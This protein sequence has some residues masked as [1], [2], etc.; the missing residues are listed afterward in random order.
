MLYNLHWT[1]STETPVFCHILLQILKGTFAHIKGKQ[2]FRA[3]RFSTLLVHWDDRKRS[4]RLHQEDRTDEKPSALC[5]GWNVLQICE[6]ATIEAQSIVTK[7][8]F[9][10]VKN[11]YGRNDDTNLNCDLIFVTWYAW[12]AFFLARS[13][14]FFIISQWWFLM[15][16]FA[17]IQTLFPKMYWK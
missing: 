15:S 1:S 8:H 7:W 5:D 4:Q 2:R 17:Q 14:F 12:Y 6:K 3:S 11:V 9:A 10:T 13:S 16:F